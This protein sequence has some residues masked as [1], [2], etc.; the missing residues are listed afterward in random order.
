MWQKS[1]SGSNGTGSTPSRRLNSQPQQDSCIK[2]EFLTE[3]ERGPDAWQRCLCMN[4][5]EELEPPGQWEP[6]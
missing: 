6:S 1:G 3:K 4:E 5:Q 2:T